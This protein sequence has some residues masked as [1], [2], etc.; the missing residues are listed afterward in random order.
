MSQRWGEKTQPKEWELK[1]GVLVGNPK[2]QIAITSP[3]NH[4]RLMQLD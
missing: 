1:T 3:G 2:A 4:L